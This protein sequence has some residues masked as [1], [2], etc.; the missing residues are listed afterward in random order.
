MKGICRW[1]SRS[2]SRNGRC[3][4][5][6]TCSVKASLVQNDLTILSI[7]V[8]PTQ[9]APHE[10]LTSY[11]RTLESDLL[12]LS[13]LSVTSKPGSPARTPSAIFLPTVDVMYPS[14]GS[15]AQDQ[16][17]RRGTVVEVKGFGDKMEG[18]SR[19][20]FFCGVAT[21]VTKLFNAVEVS[22]HPHR[23]TTAKCRSN[24]RITAN[25]RILRSKGYSTSSPAP[26]PNR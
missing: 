18:L 5:L 10:D 1:V 19:P 8:N 7:F 13:Q 2:R 21:V 17:A 16:N 12:K 15:A 24:C 9:F 23:I 14:K 4:L 6:N 20:S 22:S 25:T 11:P 26:S 3:E